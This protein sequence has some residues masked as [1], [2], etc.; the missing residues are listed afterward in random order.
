MSGRLLHASVAYD[1]KHPIILLHQHPVTKM[2]ACEIHEIKGH[3]GVESTLAAFQHTY[4][5]PKARPLID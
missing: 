4:L 5:I 3:G 1:V 2:I